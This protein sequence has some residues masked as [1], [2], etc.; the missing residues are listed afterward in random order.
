MTG[1]AR[2]STLFFDPIIAVKWPNESDPKIAPIQF[3]DPTHDISDDVSGPDDSGV[4]SGL[5][6]M[7]N[8]GD[9]LEIF[10]NKFYFLASSNFSF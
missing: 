7:G 9:T 8:A 6:K 1:T 4:L 5:A 3:M 10:W 2:N